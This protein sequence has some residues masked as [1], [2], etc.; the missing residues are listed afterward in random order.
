MNILRKGAPPLPSTPPWSVPKIDAFSDVLFGP[1]LGPL[2]IAPDRAPDA[3]GSPQVRFPP[4]TWPP[5]TSQEP[6]SWPPE[7]LLQLVF[8]RNSR[9]CVSTHQGHCFVAF[10]APNLAS[11]TDPKSMENRSQEPSFMRSFFDT[12]SKALP[13]RSW[14]P[15]WRFFSR[16]VEFWV[17]TWA[18]GHGVRKANFRNFFRASPPEALGSRPGAILAR[19]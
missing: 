18:P 3:S 5:K 14:R 8:L 2:K 4:P 17:P 7:R 10:P 16:K 15:P 9:K 19:F 11:E 13:E 12:P 6:G 1:L